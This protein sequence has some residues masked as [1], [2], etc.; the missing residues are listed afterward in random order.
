VVLNIK[1]AIFTEEKFPANM[2]EVAILHHP[3]IHK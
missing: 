3:H 1:I 2:L